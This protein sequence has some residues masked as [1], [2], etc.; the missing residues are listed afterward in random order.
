VIESEGVLAHLRMRPK[1]G[2]Q[3]SQWLEA[4]GQADRLF[5]LKGR[6]LEGALLEDTWEV[7]VLPPPGQGSRP[8]LAGALHHRLDRLTGP[9]RSAL[10]E[11]LSKLESTWPIRRSPRNFL[12]K[13]GQAHAG[14]CFLELPLLPDLAP[15]WVVTERALIIGDQ[16]A[17]IEAALL[18]EDAPGRAAADGVPS[19][20]RAPFAGLSGLRVDFER[21]RDSDRR[22]APGVPRTRPSDLWSTLSIDARP[23][24]ADQ[25]LIDARLE[26]RS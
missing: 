5:A 1:G 18:G 22:L 25:I 11:A 16:P 3:L 8:M 24:E 19:R 12:D 7:A 21:M 2:L 15:C 4:G 17:A 23:N 20:E 10:D 9:L 14:A 6:L 13:T 26:T